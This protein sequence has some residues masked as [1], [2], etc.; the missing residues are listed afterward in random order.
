LAGLAAGSATNLS[1]I[2]PDV[3]DVCTPTT[4]STELIEVV[5]TSCEKEK[6]LALDI[7]GTFGLLTV[8]FAID[9][10]P[11]YVYAV[12][13]G[14][15]QPL[16]VDALTITNGDRYSVLVQLDTPGLYTIRTA[17]TASAQMMTGYA[18][19]SY[20]EDHHAAPN[21]TSVAYID[22][23]GLNTTTDVAFFDQGAMKAHPPSP[24]GQ[25]AAQTVKLYM[26]VAGAS[27]EWALNETVYPMV[28]DSQNPMLF[29]PRPYEHDNVTITTLNNTWVDLIFITASYPMPPH[30]IHK[31]G[32]KMYL[33]GQ[34][35]GEINYSSVAEAIKSIPE[36]FNLVDPPRRD[37]LATPAVSTGP[38]W[39]AVR[40]HVTNPGAW[41]LE[42][43]P[44]YYLILSPPI[45]R[46]LIKLKERLIKLK[47]IQLNL[48][49]LTYLQK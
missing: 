4:G 10:H 3:F 8:S 27:Y 14:F 30:P 16:L 28:F 44:S 43:R 5:K 20:R 31:H 35:L 17:S 1:I 36:S 26:R 47:A 42:K 29:Q 13:G 22:D 32:N 40:Y 33:I 12:D 11:M 7:I 38:G 24:V 49:N 37:G 23:K 41:L 15:I 6:W 18:T 21:G 46:L 2:P 19:L 34:G 25:I 48:T 45:L 9:E 39:M